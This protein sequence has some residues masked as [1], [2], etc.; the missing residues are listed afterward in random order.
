MFKSLQRYEF[1][2]R[3]I[4][5][6]GAFCF[7]ISAVCEITSRD[8]TPFIFTVTVWIFVFATLLTGFLDLYRVRERNNASN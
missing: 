7:E 8:T 5:W 4:V 6:V 1:W 2:P 3:L